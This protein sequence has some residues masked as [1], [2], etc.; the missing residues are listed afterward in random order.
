MS[1]A[2]L[3]KN[4]NLQILFGV[5]LVAVMGVTSVA[6]AFPRIV[7][8]LQISI[9]DVGMLIV[10]FT[11][12]TVILTPFAGIFADRFGRKRLLV[13]S[14]LLF[15]LAG[16]ACAFSNDFNVLVLLR[17]FQGI[18]SAGINFLGVAIIGDLF[19]GEQRTEAMGLNA[20]VIG[21]GTA[22]YPLIGGAL[23]TLAW[24][25][26]FLL[27]FAG[28]PVGFIVWWFLDNPEPQSSG[29]IKEY[30]TGI[31]GYLKNIRIWG[32]FLAGIISFMVFMG[33]VLTYFALYLSDKFHASPFIIGVLISVNSVAMVLVAMQLGRLIKIMSI[34][35]LVKL[36]F[37]VCAVAIALIPLMPQLALLIIPSAL[38]G[39]GFAVIFPCIHIYVAGLVPSNYRAVFM[40]INTTMFQLGKT[41]GPMVVGLAYVYG[42]FNGAFFFTA[43][44]ALA[45]AVI[46]VI[47]G[48]FIR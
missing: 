13:P 2:K 31:W 37:A 12:P 15:G 35:N 27:A 5:T 47:G 26:P 33:V 44:L 24:N 40:A 7:E 22:S 18:G 45:T 28:V 23:A 46:G 32:A 4:K 34:A 48:R 43:G 6:P 42:G 41:L 8:D 16:G 29:N 17:V 1:K 11:I 25:Y 30:L 9:T 38:F 14:L 36:G 20:S 21:V 19:T 3:Y 39:A 10:A